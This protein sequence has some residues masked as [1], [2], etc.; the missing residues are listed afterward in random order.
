MSD[1]IFALTVLEIRYPLNFKHHLC[2][3]PNKA[4][5]LIEEFYFKRHHLVLEYLPGV[6][7]VVGLFPGQ[8]IPKALKMVLGASLLGR[9][10]SY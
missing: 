10:T 6:Q 3:A 2:R 9:F 5:F 4:V 8:V 7:E 1:I